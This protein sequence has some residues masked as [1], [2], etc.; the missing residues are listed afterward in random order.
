MLLFSTYISHVCFLL[1]GVMMCEMLTSKSARDAASALEDVFDHLSTADEA[2]ASAALQPLLDPAASWP[3]EAAVKFAAMAAACLQ[4][5]RRRPDLQKALQPA[6]EK[7]LA[8]AV[9]AAAPAQQS[10]TVGQQ[11]L[12][13]EYQAL[14]AA[15]GDPDSS[16]MMSEVPHLP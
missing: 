3:A 8:E 6:L 2:A 7:M 14:L 13:A 15:V 11:Q 5:H 10:R 1:T 16:L 12:V 9:P 4:P